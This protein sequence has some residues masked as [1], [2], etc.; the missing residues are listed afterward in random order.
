MTIY[1]VT[2]FLIEIGTKKGVGV[3]IY[4]K[5]YVN[6]EVR[7][8]IVNTD[9][10]HCL[11]IEVQGKNKRLSK[12]IS[13]V[14]QTSPANTKEI[15]W[16]EKVDLMLSSTKSTWE[17]SIILAGDMNINLTSVPQ[18]L[19]RTNKCSTH[20]NSPVTWLNQFVKVKN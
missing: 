1:P 14:Y 18:L 9:E 7:N 5:D 2:S 10:M 13:I 17:S 6:Y 4:L 11:W 8:V 3:W 16:I 12:L 15:K 20:T 19:I